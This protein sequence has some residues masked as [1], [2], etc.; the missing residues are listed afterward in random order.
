MKDT[1]PFGGI[2]AAHARLPGPTC[3]GRNPV[4]KQPFGDISRLHG[5][6][7]WTLMTFL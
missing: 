3:I 7:L 2:S 5:R 1:E 4:R 6:V